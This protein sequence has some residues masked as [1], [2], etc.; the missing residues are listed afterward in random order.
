MCDN[1]GHC[2]WSTVPVVKVDGNIQGNQCRLELVCNSEEKVCIYKVYDFC[3]NSA[4]K[5]DEMIERQWRS[6]LLQKMRQ[7]QNMT[8]EK[9]NQTRKGTSAQISPPEFV[10]SETTS[11]PSSSDS[12]LPKDTITTTINVYKVIER[13]NT[14]LDFQ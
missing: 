7:L 10:F 14:S 3:N 4:M 13:K 9:T 12:T 6:F 1:G 2:T 5:K 11:K 8:T